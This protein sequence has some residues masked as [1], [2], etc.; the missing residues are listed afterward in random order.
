MRRFASAGVRPVL[1]TTW[2]T[3]AE[4]FAVSR[5]AHPALGDELQFPA[6]KRARTA[7]LRPAMRRIGSGLMAAPSVIEQ[8]LIFTVDD[9]ER[10]IVRLGLDCDNAMPAP[11]GFVVPLGDGCCR[12][13]GRASTGSSIGS[14]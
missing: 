12:F 6:R 10:Q 1:L 2:A 9:P 14:S 4:S 7:P 3:S 11:D 8:R 13:R 5:M